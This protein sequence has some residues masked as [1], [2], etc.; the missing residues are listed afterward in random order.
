MQWWS[1]S[2]TGGLY[3]PRRDCRWSWT[4]GERQPPGYYPGSAWTRMGTFTSLSPVTTGTPPS[5]KGVR[6]Y[7]QNLRHPGKEVPIG[8]W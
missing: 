6:E 7:L 8:W 2:S 1:G 4:A 5:S 3:S